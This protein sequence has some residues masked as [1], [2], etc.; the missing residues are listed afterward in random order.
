VSA[1]GRAALR[2]GPALRRCLAAHPPPRL[3]PVPFSRGH[4][5]RGCVPHATRASMPATVAA[6]GAPWSRAASAA[7]LRPLRRPPPPPKVR[8][9]RPWQRLPPDRPVVPHGRAGRLAAR[10]AGRGGRPRRV[11]AVDRRGVASVDG[12]G[13]E[14]GDRC[15]TLMG[16]G[17][18]V[19]S[20]ARDVPTGIQRE[21]GS[22]VGLG[23]L[24]PPLLTEHALAFLYHRFASSYSRDHQ[25]GWPLCSGSRRL[26]SDQLES[27][28][29]NLSCKA[30]AST[31]DPN[32][33]ATAQLPR[34]LP[35]ARGW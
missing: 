16:G 24:A 10:P 28:S 9:P 15:G 1:G 29:R 6:C 7:A 34:P 20:A 17:T 21:R 14:G 5:R 11:S 8:P 26:D 32:P 23:Y 3:L 12:A 13:F 30:N 33:P 18:S 35:S 2:T 22:S 19:G 4:R 25:S 31:R 27:E